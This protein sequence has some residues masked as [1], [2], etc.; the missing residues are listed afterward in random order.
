MINRDFRTELI[1]E[2]PEVFFRTVKLGKEDQPPIFNIDGINYFYLQRS[3]V[4]IVATTRFNVSPS[5]ILELLNQIVRVIKDFCGVLN[6]EAIRKNFVMI[7]EILDEMIDFGYPQLT[8]TEQ[9]KDFIVAT[10]ETCS[11]FVI[12]RKNIFNNNT[13]KVT[14]TMDPIANAA[15]RNEIFVDVIEK[16]NVLF[17]SSNTV[18]NATIDGSIRMKS[19]LTG[20]PN[21]KLTLNPDSYFDDYNFDESVDDSDFNFNRK[22]SINPPA[23]EFVAMNYRMSRD[24][25]LPFK[26]F[27]FLHQETP[28]KV[29]LSLKVKC[30]LPFDN[31]AKLVIVE[32]SM[33][34]M[35]SSVSNELEKESKNQKVHFNEEQRVVVWNIESFPG[36]S[37][38][39]LVTRISLNKEVS[40]YQLRKEIGPVKMKFEINQMNSSPLKIKS[41]LI[42]GTD[43]E[44]PSKWVRYITTSNSYVIRL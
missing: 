39:T 43:K 1:R 35:M 27:P 21:L 20:F 18:I 12:P 32:F 16:V 38:H 41:L 24:F 3:S 33:P 15:K 6:E 8:S 22:L 40:M 37:E 30:E 14:A 19:F 28:F 10:P 23:G 44:N 2:T 9:I 11:G 4:F 5:L 29:E 31:S 25:L 34:E 26:V 7:Y 42:E 13:I 36:N 17:N